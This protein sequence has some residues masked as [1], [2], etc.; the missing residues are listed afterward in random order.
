[1]VA[2]F[3]GYLRVVLRSFPMYL[4]ALSGTAPT[5]DSD[6]ARANVHQA[7]SRDSVARLPLD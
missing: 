2:G 1:M 7:D 5:S 3:H 4:S 6:P